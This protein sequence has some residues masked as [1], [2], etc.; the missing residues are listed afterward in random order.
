MG[1]GIVLTKIPWK[2]IVK[3]ALEIL[4]TALLSYD[5]LK[6]KDDSV[7]EKDIPSTI[8]EFSKK[9]KFLEANDEQQSK[10]IAE[11]AKQAQTF[12]DGLRVLGARVTVLLWLSIIAIALCVF[13]LVKEFF[14]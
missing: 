10:I 4:R 12:S 2:S 9:V 8:A 5:Q 13:L 3:T 14:L 7:E 11:L 1:V 6:K